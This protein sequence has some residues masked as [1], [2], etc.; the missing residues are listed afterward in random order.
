LGA[1][2]ER[3]ET[4]AYV[5]PRRVFYERGARILVIGARS[6]IGS[7]LIE[8]LLARRETPRA[9]IPL[10]QDGELH[11]PESVDMVAGELADPAS[12]VEAMQGVDRV[13]LL[14]EPTPDEVRLN[15]NA[16]RVAKGMGIRLLVRCSTLGANPSSPAVLIR[17]H[18]QSDRYLEQSRLPYVIL[19]PNRLLQSVVE[20]T[21]PS[22][23]ADG[24]FAVNAGSARISMV[25]ARDVAAAAATV[26]T[27]PGHEGRRYDVTG[28]EALSYGEVA[29]RLARAIGW[30][31]TYVDTAD[32]AMRKALRASGM[33]EWRATAE[34]EL[35]AEYRRGGAFGYAS[36]VTETVERLTG[37]A[38]R[39]LDDV[40]E[41][42][43][44]DGP[45]PPAA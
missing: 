27:E 35:F 39:T 10:D 34:A 18:G 40:I 12:L 1:P 42:W 32:D 6:T 36:A 31:T 19:R 23:D 17:D 38:P 9:L 2:V 7:A 44:P 21:I 8:E 24:R 4:T 15:S 16:I 45:R 14:S 22:I 13:F 5:T 20:T 30:P 29:R 43:L 11:F 3:P 37:R 33:D 25:D 28:P 41:E 26:L